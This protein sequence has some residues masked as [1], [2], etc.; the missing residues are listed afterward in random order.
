[1]YTTCKNLLTTLSPKLSV[2]PGVQL[3]PCAACVSTCLSSWV[4][5]SSRPHS[6]SQEGVV[7]TVVVDVVVIVVV[8]DV[9]EVVVSLPRP[10][11]R[12]RGGST[13]SL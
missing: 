7:A 11:G 13:S 5:R 10:R 3:E 9:E 8:V 2:V 4:T 12:A 6:S 1:M